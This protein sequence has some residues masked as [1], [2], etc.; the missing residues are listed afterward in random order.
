MAFLGPGGNT[1]T[2]NDG[3]FSIGDVTAGTYRV[4]ASV[5]MIMSTRSGGVA[6]SGGVGGGSNFTSWSVSSSGV[7][8]TVSGGTAPFEVVVAD[9]DVRGVR[10]VVHRPPPPQ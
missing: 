9:A 10:V 7:T 8:T 2:G 3:R 1:Q 4:N 5:P 6:A